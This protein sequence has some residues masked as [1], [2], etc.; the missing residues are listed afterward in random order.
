MNLSGE[1]ISTVNNIYNSLWSSINTKLN[2]TEIADP[3]SSWYAYKSY[4]ENHLSYSEATK[5][6]VLSSKGYF[7]DSANEFDNIDSESKNEGFKQRKNLFKNSDWI[8]FV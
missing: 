8:F 5:R 7:K 6:N 4:L 2:G 3:T 1:N